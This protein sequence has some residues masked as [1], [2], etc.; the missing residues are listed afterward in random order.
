M[1]IE[2]HGNVTLESLDVNWV[3]WAMLDIRRSILAPHI[4]L[5]SAI[6]EQTAE[7]RLAR[8]IDSFP[9]PGAAF[10]GV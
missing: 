1:V 3:R 7:Q 4:C 10:G 6:Y 5:F 8:P 2:T 9:I